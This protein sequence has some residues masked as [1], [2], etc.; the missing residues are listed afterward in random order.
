MLCNDL[1]M[2]LLFKRLISNLKVSS[3]SGC[4]QKAT[5]EHQRKKVAKGKNEKSSKFLLFWLVQK[6]NFVR[7][8]SNSLAKNACESREG[9]QN[10]KRLD[11]ETK[12]KGFAAFFGIEEDPQV[13]KI[14]GN[15]E[16]RK[17]P[18]TRNYGPSEKH[19]CWEFSSPDH[20][21]CGLC[22]SV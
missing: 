8:S 22:V 11:N 13:A 1:H 5:K 12:K 19:F 3:I 14:K 17:E 2:R 15:H 6:S 20:M 9:K 10:K 7:G 16:E 4:S 18:E 21:W